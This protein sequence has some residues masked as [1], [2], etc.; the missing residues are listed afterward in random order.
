[1][2]SFNIHLTDSAGTAKERLLVVRGDSFEQGLQHGESA[3]DLIRQNLEAVKAQLVGRDQALMDRAYEKAAAYVETHHPDT[4]AEYRGMA[5]GSGLPLDDILTLNLKVANVLDWLRVECSQFA[6]VVNTPDGRTRTLLAK[7]RDQKGGAVE[8]VVLVRQYSDGVESLEVHKAGIISY[9]GSVMTTR[10]V[11]AGTSGVWSKRTPFDIDRLDSADVGTDAHALLIG[12]DGL[13]DLIRIQST[14]PRL[15]GIN[16]VVAEAGRV[17]ALELTASDAEFFDAGNGSVVRTNH[18]RTPRFQEVSPQ[19]AEYESTFHRDERITALLGEATTP[20]DFWAIAQ[21]HVGAPQE[22]V[23]RHRNEAGQ[24]SFTTY[25][26][27]FE[28]ETRSAWI[29]FGQ[30][31]ELRFPE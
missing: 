21:D 20:Q 29:G 6:K 24:G 28:L 3:P 31:C 26:S 12:A 22:S 5:E 7:T 27:V 2:S 23:C 10:G 30:P 8:H 25:F 11:A 1:M 14:L 4:W 19:R 13:S 9:P 17:G 15:T 18:Y 16:N